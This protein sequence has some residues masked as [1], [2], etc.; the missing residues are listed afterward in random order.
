MAE[1]GWMDLTSNTGVYILTY[2][3]QLS[4]T[5]AGLYSPWKDIFCEYVYLKLFTFLL[6]A[7][8]AA[9]SHSH[10]YFI[11]FLQGSNAGFE[12]QEL[13][14]Y[15]FMIS[16]Y[17]VTVLLLIQVVSVCFVTVHRSMHSPL[18][19]PPVCTASSCVPCR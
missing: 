8:N 6:N 5:Q 16:P 14:Q 17:A 3:P 9:P 13:L 4:V 7:L 19:C 15:R 1:N 18:Y 10:G 2:I 11:T 12:R